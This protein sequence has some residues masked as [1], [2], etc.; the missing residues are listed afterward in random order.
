MRWRLGLVLWVL[1]SA[2]TRTAWAQQMASSGARWQPTLSAGVWGMS[3]RSNDEPVLGQMAAIEF[4]R[5]RPGRRTAFVATLAGYTKGRGKSFME[6]PYP[7]G[8]S[9]RHREDLLLLGLGADWAL[10]NGPVQWTA[11]VSLAAG[12]GRITTREIT[13]TGLTFSGRES[14]DRGWHRPSGVLSVTSGVVLPVSSAWGIRLGGQLFQ[15]V[16]TFA[17]RGPSFGLHVGAV[18]R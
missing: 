11:G 8:R 16:E 6:M 14:D 2:Q 15:G 12:T 7:E 5:M 13:N 1:V 10:V 3:T 17:E 18:L 9:Y 4:R